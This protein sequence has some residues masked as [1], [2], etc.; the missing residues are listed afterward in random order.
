[1]MISNG[2]VDGNAVNGYPL[3]GGGFVEEMGGSAIVA[4]SPAGEAKARRM[5]SGST[6]VDIAGRLITAIAGISKVSIVVSGSMTARRLATGASGAA[7]TFTGIALRRPIANGRALIRLISFG[8]AGYSY[9]RPTM[10]N[11]R[12]FIIENRRTLV[13][14]EDRSFPIHADPRRIVVPRESEAR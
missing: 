10:R 13:R 12:N 9:L 1:M 11:R 6:A 8:Q 7:L 5:A 4:V 3:N 2:S 14:S